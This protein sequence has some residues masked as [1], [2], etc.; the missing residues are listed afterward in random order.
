MTTFNFAHQVIAGLDSQINSIATEIVELESHLAKLRDAQKRIENERQ[1]MLTLA[2]A[3][4]S[5]LEQA[6]NFLSMAKAANRTDMIEA[7][8]TGIDGLRNDKPQLTACDEADEIVCNTEPNKPIDPTEGV[9]PNESTSEPSDNDQPDL[10]NNGTTAPIE[11]SKDTGNDDAT[12][13]ESE[14]TDTTSKP[15]WHSLNW[16]EFL[17]YAKAKGIKTNRK[18][19]AEIELALLSQRN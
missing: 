13:N 15:E 17:K 16:R 7:F 6:S 8:W 9:I 3:G 10:S 14:A 1:A 4:E 11:P 2:K 19:R 5:A 12:I 18:T